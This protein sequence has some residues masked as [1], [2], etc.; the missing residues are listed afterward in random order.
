MSEEELHEAIER[1][2][3]QPENTFMVGKQTYDLLQELGNDTVW[4]IGPIYINWSKL[5][6]KFRKS[7][8]G[9]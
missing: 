9:E 7:G 2:S 4:W 1:L 6:R 3:V 8:E 5:R